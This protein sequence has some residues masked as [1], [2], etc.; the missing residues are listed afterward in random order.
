MEA[1]VGVLGTEVPLGKKKQAKP[2]WWE[3]VW[4]FC[5]RNSRKLL[6]QCDKEKQ[7]NVRCYYDVSK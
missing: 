5:L 2:R 7:L 4:G 6:R 1:E 3:V